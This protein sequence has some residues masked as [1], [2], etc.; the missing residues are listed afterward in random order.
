[1]HAN[2]REEV[3]TVYAGEI[4]AAVGLKTTRTSDTLCDEKNPIELH[5]IEFAEPVISMRIE[6]KTKADQEK[7]GIALKRLS[8][9]DPTFRVTSDQ[10]TGETVISGMGELHLEI[11]VD[12]MKREFNVEANVG[13]PQVAYRETI[14]GSAEA[15][16]KYIKQSGGKG[17]Y[18]HV[19]IKIK[20]LEKDVNLEKLPKN[21]KR[22]PGFEFINNIKGGAIP[23]EFIPAC[24]KGFKEALD[25][26]VVAGY[27]ITDVSVELYD[28]SYHDVDSSEL[29]FKLAASMAFQEA[30]R[31]ANPVILEPIMKVEVIVPEEFTGDIT[32][33]LSSKRGQ[34]E[35]MDDRGN[36]MTTIHAK[37]PLSELFGYTTI[38]RSMTQGRGSATIEP[39]HYAIVPANVAMEISAGKK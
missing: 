31:R 8:D 39:D 24:E 26:G 1:M 37:V 6:P 20:P 9:E 21:I 7:M 32:G 4:A 12:R 16:H 15:E 2:E 28:G 17:Q 34:V 27:R 33:N 36:G 10:E 22:E 38:L 23:G 29:A 25:R 13:K 18:G 19:K 30:A 35:G 3:Q 14:N 11:I 5:R